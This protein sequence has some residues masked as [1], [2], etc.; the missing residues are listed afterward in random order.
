[1]IKFSDLRGSK[2]WRLHN[3]K[4]NDMY[5]SPSTIWVIK[6]RIMKWPGHLARMGEGRCAY[7]VLVGTSEGKKSLGKFRHRWKD[8]TKMNLQEMSWGA[9]TELIWLRKGTGC[10]LL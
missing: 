10:G 5:S 6:S 3:E 9:W 2:E 7:R 8:N 1:V 4:L